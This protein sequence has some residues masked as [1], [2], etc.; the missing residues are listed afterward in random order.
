MRADLLQSHQNV[1]RNPN[2]D[3]RSVDFSNHSKMWSVG[4]LPLEDCTNYTETSVGT[5]PMRI[6]PREHTKLS[7]GTLPARV[8]TNHDEMSIVTLPARPHRNVHQNLS[9]RL[10]RNV[11]RHPSRQTTP[12]WS[13]VTLPVRTH[14]NVQHHPSRQ[15][16]PKY[17]L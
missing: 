8:C 11:D 17:R 15:T 3:S 12:E 10:H 16:T 13:I 1:D 5:F 7:I 14:R 9:A 2:R 6:D 4:T